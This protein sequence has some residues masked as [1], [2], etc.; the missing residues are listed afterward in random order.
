MQVYSLYIEIAIEKEQTMPSAS[1]SQAG[2]NCR[3]GAEQLDESEE[4]EK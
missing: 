3:V 2:I 4:R 1:V